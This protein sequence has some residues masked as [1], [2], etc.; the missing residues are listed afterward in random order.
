MDTGTNTAATASL[1]RRADYG[2]VLPEAVQGL[3]KTSSVLGKG[4]LDQRLRKLVEL[5]VSQLN[6]CAYCCALHSK[7]ARALGEEQRRLDALPGWDDA[8]LF[9]DAEQAAL[10][11]AEAL[12]RVGERRAPQADYDALAATFSERQIVELTMAIALMN[13]WNR[14]SVALGRTA[15]QV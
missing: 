14:L 9:S 4:E 8:G 12:T 13:T 10:R 5:R 7:E 3:A 6:G 2:K 1:P 11:W 15:D